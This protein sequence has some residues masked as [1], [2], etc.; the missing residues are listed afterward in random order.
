MSKVKFLIGDATD[1]DGLQNADGQFIIAVDESQLNAYV[2]YDDNG[3]IVRKQV[4]GKVTGIKGNSE[5]T[6]RTGDVNITAAD[7]RDHF[8]ILHFQFLQSCERKHSRALCDKLV[9]FNQRE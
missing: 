1:L 5:A 9:F 4:G 7:N 6:Y 8:L 2:D 3:T